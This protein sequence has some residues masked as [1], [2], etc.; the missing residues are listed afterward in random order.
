MIE[1]LRA[2]WRMYQS[3]RVTETYIAVALTVAV[4][5]AFLYRRQYR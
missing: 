5:G 2:A 1:A 3:D 4:V